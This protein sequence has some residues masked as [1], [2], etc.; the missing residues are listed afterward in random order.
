MKLQ[1]LEDTFTLTLY[2]R[3]IPG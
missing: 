1:Q 3:G 2:F